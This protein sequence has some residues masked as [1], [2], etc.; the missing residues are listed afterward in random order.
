M[1]CYV[2]KNTRIAQSSLFRTSLVSC[3]SRL[4]F[5]RVAPTSSSSLII[6]CAVEQ[7]CYSCPFA[8]QLPLDGCM[9]R[10]FQYRLG[11]HYN[12]LF[13]RAIDTVFFVV[14]G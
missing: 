3:V 2:S 7:L 13:L 9:V 6:M 4:F 5:C 10:L 8:N 14:V 1:Q 11:I 12:I